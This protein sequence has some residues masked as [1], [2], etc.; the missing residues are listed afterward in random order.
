MG[1]DILTGV[2]RKR[3]L[4]FRYCTFWT[5]GLCIYVRSSMSIFA[6][7][8]AEHDHHPLENETEGKRRGNWISFAIPPRSGRGGGGAV[9]NAP[10]RTH[11][12]GPVRTLT[13]VLLF[14]KKGSGGVPRGAWVVS[15]RIPRGEWMKQS[16][17]HGKCIR[18][19]I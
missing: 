15:S 14:Q 6:N 1:I 9:S 4:T 7:V 2:G 8:N 16:H 18:S 17:H 5:L 13:G 3:G 12:R 19:T 10:I 11:E